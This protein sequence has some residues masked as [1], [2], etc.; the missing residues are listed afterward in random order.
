MLQGIST[1]ASCVVRHQLVPEIAPEG[2]GWIYGQVISEKKARRIELCSSTN[3][4][5]K[6]PPKLWETWGQ[7]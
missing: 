7:P 1:F 4:Q 2:T 3:E 6:S 5:L